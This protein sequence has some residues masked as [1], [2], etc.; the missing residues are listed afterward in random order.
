MLLFSNYSLFWDRFNAVVR[1]DRERPWFL[2][3]NILK[4]YST[5]AQSGYWHWYSQ[6][7][8]FYHHKDPCIYLLMSN[9]LF[10]Y[11]YPFLTSGKHLSV[12]HFYNF[13]ISRMLYKWNHV[14]YNLWELTFSTQHNSLEIHPSRWCISVFFLIIAE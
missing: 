2:S 6:K 14:V 9:S 3:S 13:I 10:S 8:H 12:L 7:V 5:I 4:N 11:P 1:H